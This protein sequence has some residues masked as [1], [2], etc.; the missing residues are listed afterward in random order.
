MRRLMWTAVL[1]IVLSPVPIP[2]QTRA[3]S[4]AVA[5]VLIRHVFADVSSQGAATLRL[6]TSP[7]LP[8]ETLDFHRLVRL[9]AN[10][11][12][13]LTSD[14]TSICPETDPERRGELDLGVDV[15]Q[16]L[17]QEAL[18]EISLS[19]G[20]P[21]DG[22]TGHT[23]KWKYTIVRAGGLWRIM[24]VDQVWHSQWMRQR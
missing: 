23:F 7:D 19:C 15:P 11:L 6:E 18:V 20:S 4:L 8:Q 12:S 14:G 24:R 2:A 22:F 9:E 13:L 21:P 1:G 5:G 10:H 3:D 16:F 17:A